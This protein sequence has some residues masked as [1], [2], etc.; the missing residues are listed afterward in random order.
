MESLKVVG[1]VS[2]MESLKVM[3]GGVSFRESFKLNGDCVVVFECSLVTLAEVLLLLALL[4]LLL[5]LMK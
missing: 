4:L 1:W 5:L 2:F 3:G